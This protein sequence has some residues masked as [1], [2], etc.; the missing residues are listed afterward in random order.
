[1]VEENDCFVRNGSN[2][3]YNSALFN[4]VIKRSIPSITIK[5]CV[6]VKIQGFIIL[7]FYDTFFGLDT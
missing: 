4:V 5:P 6:E 3:V 2:S 7:L 1:M